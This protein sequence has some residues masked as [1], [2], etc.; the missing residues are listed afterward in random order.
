MPVAWMRPLVLLSVCTVGCM[1][2][3]AARLSIGPTLDTAARVGIELRVEGQLGVAD[4]RAEGAD[5][6][7]V[8]ATT[9]AYGGVGARD[10]PDEVLTAAA[11]GGFGVRARWLDPQLV[12]S[13]AVG[14][15]GRLGVS[16]AGVATS[17]AGAFGE[18][19]LGLHVHPSVVLGIGLAGEGLV[20]PALGIFYLPLHA[21]LS[22]P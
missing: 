20:D 22:W 12:V 19:A 7:L 9:V 5:E 8:A 6:V 16:H 14:P 17:A 13:G 3:A 21:E 1:P 18:V 15:A 2:V 10:V 11:G 4:L